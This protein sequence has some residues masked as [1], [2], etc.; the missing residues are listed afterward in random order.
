MGEVPYTIVFGY[1]GAPIYWSGPVATVV[2]LDG[3]LPSYLFEIRDQ[4]GGRVRGTWRLTAADDRKRLSFYEL[5]VDQFGIT[6][7]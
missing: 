4:E 1:A 3:S 6:G 2:A 7:R 5:E